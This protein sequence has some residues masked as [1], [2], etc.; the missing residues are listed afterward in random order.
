M[1]GKKAKAQRHSAN[2]VNSKQD[3]LDPNQSF[4]DTPFRISKNSWPA[5]LLVSEIFKRPGPRNFR[6]QIQ[7]EIRGSRNLRYPKFSIGCNVY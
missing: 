2:I 5:K 6:C 3:T 1:D 4:S 7:P